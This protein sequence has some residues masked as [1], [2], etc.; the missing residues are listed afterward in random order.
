M[1]ASLTTVLVV[2]KHVVVAVAVEPIYNHN[3]ML[4]KC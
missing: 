3:K 2:T 1:S 4:V